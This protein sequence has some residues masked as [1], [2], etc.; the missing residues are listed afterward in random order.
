MEVRKL[1][2]MLQVAKEKR[3][4]WEEQRQAG[5]KELLE[6]RQATAALRKEKEGYALT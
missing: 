3:K 5:K 1:E 4:E 6:L 2:A